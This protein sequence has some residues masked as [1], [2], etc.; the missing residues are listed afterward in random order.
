MKNLKDR[1]FM[2]WNNLLMIFKNVL[3]HERDRI[4]YGQKNVW[5]V[6]IRVK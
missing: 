3:T 2:S 5:P 1:A 6:S 4:V